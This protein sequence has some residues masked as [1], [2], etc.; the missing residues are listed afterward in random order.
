[1]LKHILIL[2]LLLAITPLQ[3][4]VHRWVDE[5]GN[6][7]YSDKAPAKQTSEKVEIKINAPDP[8]T[9]ERLLRQKQVVESS[10]E[11]REEQKEQQQAEAKEAEQQKERCKSARA[12]LHLAESGGR[13]FKMDEN[14]D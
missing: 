2:L 12:Q 3:A 1:M 10:Q 6:V 14:E 7:H 13:M 11:A 8:V 9:Q 4:A 5:N